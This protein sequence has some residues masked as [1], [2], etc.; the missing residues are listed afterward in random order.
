VAQVGVV[1][2]VHAAFATLL[3]Q[4][5]RWEGTLSQTRLSPVAEVLRAAAA[6]QAAPEAPLEA[7]PA[8]EPVL[9]R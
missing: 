5:P 8:R 6:A 4:A 1:M 9:A 3:A 7:S 2:A